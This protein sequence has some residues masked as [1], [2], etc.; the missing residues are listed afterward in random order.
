MDKNTVRQL[1]EQ[2]TREELLELV[3]YLA[4]SDRAVRQKLLDFCQRK[5]KGAESD[6]FSLIVEEQIGIYWSNAKEIIAEFDRYGGGPEWEEETVYEELEKMAGLFKEHQIPWAVRRQ[7]LD[8]MLPFVASDNSGFTDCLVDVAS[9]LCIAREEKIY[10]ADFLAQKGNSY[11]Q[12][13]AARIYREFGEDA[14]FLEHQ[15]AHLEYGED[16]VELADYYIQHGDEKQALELLWEGVR[17]GEGGLSELYQYMFGYFKG[18]ED[19]E[20]LE[21]LYM[22]SQKR[23]R[24]KDV[25]LEL[26]HQ[27]YRE[28][29]EYERQK[30]TILELFAYID[31]NDLYKLYE[32]CKKELTAEDFA[33]EEKNILEVIRKRNLSA[34]LNILMDK[35]ETEDV[36]AYILQHP[37]RGEWDDIDADHYFSKRLAD[38]HPREVVEMYWN[39][40]NEFVGRRRAKN[41]GHVVGVLKEIKEIM[42]GNK[43]DEEW[44]RRYGEFLRG[45]EK[46]RALMREVGRI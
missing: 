45:N 6:K 11:Y 4:D 30:E 24:G 25:I 42:R 38:Q 15:K 3:E 5:E 32:E 12:D 26:M 37:N 27:Y 40:V 10:L 22:I 28:K 18:I 35:R 14:K 2:Y 21:K 31:K 36:L 9:D 8:E 16:Y 13:V 39:E 43:W 20:S 33:T 17:K 23:P 34:Y 7:V 1:I 19:E 44:E 29:G 41:Y 46:K